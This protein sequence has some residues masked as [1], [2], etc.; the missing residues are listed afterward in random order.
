MDIEEIYKKYMPAIYKNFQ[1]HS[2]INITYDMYLTIVMEVIRDM[3]IILQNGNHNKELI[4]GINTKL[5]EFAKKHVNNPDYLYPM[6]NSFVISNFEGVKTVDESMKSFGRFNNLL[7]KLD[8]IPEPDTLIDLLKNNKDLN[9]CTAKVFRKYR[10]Y[11]IDGDIDYVISNEILIE[12]LNAYCLINDIEIKDNLD[13]IIDDDPTSMDSLSLYRREV[14][15]YPLLSKAEEQELAKRMAEGDINARERFINCNLRLVM[16][17]AGKIKRPGV[18]YADLLQDGNIG[19]IVSVDKFDPSKGF[20]FSTYAT[21]W[22]RREMLIGIMN[23]SRTIRIPVHRYEEINNFKRIRAVLSNELGRDPT[24]EDIAKKMRISVKKAEKIM[25]LQEDS[26]SINTKIGEED[27]LELG[28]VIPDVNGSVDD[29]VIVNALSSDIEELFKKAGLKP[30]E[31]EILIYRFGLDGNEP[32]TLEEICAKYGITRERTRQVESIAKKKIRNCE[33]IKEFAVYMDDIDKVLENISEYRKYY[34]EHPGSYKNFDL[35]MDKKEKA[36]KEKKDMPKKLQSIYE[37]FD[38]YTRDEVDKAISMLPEEDKALVKKRYG[39]DLDH[40]VNTGLSFDESG[41]FYGAVMSRIKKNLKDI[42]AKERVDKT[43][44]VKERK[45]E[46]ERVRL[47]ILKKKEEE[48]KEESPFVKH[49]RNIENGTSTPKLDDYLKDFTKKNAPVLIASDKVD[50]KE[51]EVIPIGEE[52]K[53]TEELK[54][55]TPVPVIE[56]KEEPEEIDLD[57]LRKI[58]IVDETP[59]SQLEQLKS[60]TLKE[61][62]SNMSP[63]EA[64]IVCLKFGYIDDKYFTDDAIKDFLGVESK[65][66]REATMKVLLSYKDQITSLVDDIIEKGKPKVLNN[67]TPKK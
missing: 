18:P 47:E 45:A 10:K 50:G 59:V 60:L 65:D 7:E 62:M 5:Y 44:Q 34:L 64:V 66:I 17:V 54:E 42:R 67:K 51:V 43:K 37:L 14:N 15:Q 2:F 27:D 52:P 63:K 30:R 20:K 56:V 58:R 38:I 4:D 9:E 35:E 11:I 57:E 8:Y 53:K 24:L 41:K 13:E 23:K 1:S 28:D 49:L 6:L 33:F 55:K 40:P 29:K 48:K 22:I 25:R 26:V 36:R 61:M 21:H 3:K 46:Q 16:S 12:L 39:D 32:M 31:R 19:L